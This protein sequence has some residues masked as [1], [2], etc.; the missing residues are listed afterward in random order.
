MSVGRGSARAGAL[1]ICAFVQESR[2]GVI[3]INQRPYTVHWMTRPVYLV[4]FLQGSGRVLKSFSRK[5]LFTND[6]I[7]LLLS[8]GVRTLDA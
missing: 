2:K 3:I 4:G 8:S 7:G 1:I 6:G 5:M